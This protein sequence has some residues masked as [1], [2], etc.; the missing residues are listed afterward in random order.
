MKQPA[1]VKIITALTLLI[2][3]ALPAAATLQPE[4]VADS[5]GTIAVPAPAIAP[6][7][8]EADSAAEKQSVK[9][10]V[11]QL[12]DNGFHINDP[13]IRYP[14]FARFCLKVYNWG[15]RTFNSYDTTYVVATGKNWKFYLRNENWTESFLF[16]FPKSK[17]IRM[18]T[19][20]YSDLGVSLNFMAVALSYTVNAKTLFT[21]TIE[22][23]SRWNF[24]F[25]CALF[26]ASLDYSKNQGGARIHQLCGYE[27]VKEHSMRFDDFTSSS[28]NVSGYYFFNHRKYSQAAAYCYSKYQ[29]RSAGTWLAGLWYG[30]QNIDIDFS[31]LP[32]QMLLH[33]PTEERIFRFHY[34]DFCIGGGYAYNW[35]IKPRKWLFNITAFPSVGL[36]K[37]MEDA[38]EGNRSMLSTNMRGMMDLTYNHRALFASVTANM[39]AS[40]Y[41][42]PNY[43]FINTYGV[44]S[45][46]VG[47][48]F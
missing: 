27:P 48:R 30:R 3:N 42:S 4:A 15:D 17:Q 37:T 46:M 32:Q 34:R 2:I 12:I 29:L 26:S 39:L 7:T 41:I 21:H 25:T 47:I 23:R 18:I 10:W 45:A 9:G 35:V 44:A 24:S 36:R 5:V 1:I 22:N 43:T 6:A 38:T 40:L 31:H 33:L 16:V 11:R 20:P 14:R 28:L 8:V 13:A 19:E